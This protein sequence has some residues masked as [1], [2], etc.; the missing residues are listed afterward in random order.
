MLEACC[1]GAAEGAQGWMPCAAG[2]TTALLICGGGGFSFDRV[3]VFGVTFGSSI[4]SIALD[5]K[6]GAVWALRATF[7]SSDA[8]SSCCSGWRA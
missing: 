6:S 2:G 8:S 7:A 4:N 5:D 1:G 3:L